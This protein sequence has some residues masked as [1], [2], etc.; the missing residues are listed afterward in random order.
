MT[1]ILAT[2]NEHLLA[3]GILSCVLARGF[4]VRVLAFTVCVNQH[5]LAGLQP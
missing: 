5:L 3:R 2:A 4:V 1:V